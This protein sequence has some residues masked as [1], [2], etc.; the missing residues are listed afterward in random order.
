MMIG[1][2][3]KFMDYPSWREN[4]PY[5]SPNLNDYRRVVGNYP[6]FAD[7]FINRPPR[8]T[9]EANGALRIGVRVYKL[10]MADPDYQPPRPDMDAE[11]LKVICVR[12]ADG[13]T[14]WVGM[15]FSGDSRAWN[16]K[17]GS[18]PPGYCKLSGEKSGFS[19]DESML[20]L[21]IASYDLLLIQ[22]VP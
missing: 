4:L 7:T 16:T 22:S 6:L 17:L 9:T 15:N 10:V 18:L 5:D 2:R 8:D 20:T 3:R 12:G 1:K 19:V 13:K 21:Q 14:Y 11:G